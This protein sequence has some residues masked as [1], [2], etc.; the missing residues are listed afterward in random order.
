VSICELSLK[1]H[2]SIGDRKLAMCSWRDHGSKC[3]LFVGRFGRDVKSANSL[4]GAAVSL[5]VG[6][7]ADVYDLD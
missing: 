3:F 7:A 6:W 4:A 2:I 5:D 1:L